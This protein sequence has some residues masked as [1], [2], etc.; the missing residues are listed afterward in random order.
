MPFQ[1]GVN[2]GFCGLEQIRNMD[3]IEPEVPEYDGDIYFRDEEYDDTKPDYTFE[4]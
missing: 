3:V 1:T 4:G 2:P